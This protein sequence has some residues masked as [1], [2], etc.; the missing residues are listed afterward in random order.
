MQILENKVAIVTGSSRGIGRA[1]AIAF[2]QEGCKVVVNYC[3]SKESAMEV[4]EE[5]ERINPNGSI[6]I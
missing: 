3:H 2:A 6:V 4:S 1:I 5:I